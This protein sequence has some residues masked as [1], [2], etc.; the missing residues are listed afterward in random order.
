MF[1]VIRHRGK[2]VAATFAALALAASLGAGSASAAN[3]H[4]KNNQKPTFTDNGLTLTAAGALVGLG[5]QNVRVVLSAQGNPTAIC[6]NPS[7][8]QQPPG[9]NPATVTLTGS[10]NI[11][12]TQIKNGNV[13]FNVTTAPPVSPIPGAPGCPGSNWTETITDVAFTSATITV[14]QPPGVNNV[15]F[16]LRCSFSPATSDGTVP[17]SSVTCQ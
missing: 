4:L 8:K 7:G 1:T 10:Q 14:Q 16:T 6:T 3:V 12:A 5:N 13:S 17:T 11:P 9:R 15:V 2:T